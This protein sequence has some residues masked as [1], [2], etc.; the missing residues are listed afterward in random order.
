MRILEN[1][2]RKNLK[3]KLIW[4]CCKM[5]VYKDK[6]CICKYMA[7]LKNFV[8]SCISTYGNLPTVQYDKTSITYRDINSFVLSKKANNDT[9][10]KMRENIIGA[11]INKN[12]P[13][14]F[15]KY[16]PRW[17]L[18]KKNIDEYLMKVIKERSSDVNEIKSAKCIHRGG[19]LY[20][21]DFT[22]IINDS[23]DF[24]IELKFNASNI[25]E[26]PQYV[27]P[28]KPSQYLSSSFEE[29]YYENFLPKL[30]S[31]SNTHLP[32][33][34][35]DEYMK[36]IH[37]PSPSCVEEF[38]AKYYRGCK[39][40]SKYSGLE[41]DI[42]FYNTAI[43]LSKESISQFIEKTEL[44]CEKLSDYL[45]ETQKDKIYMLFKDNKF[46]MDKPNI[47]DYT[48]VGYTKMP[49]KAMYLANSQTGNKIKIL[50]RWKNGNGIAYP[51]FQIS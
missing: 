1:I 22:V 34:N 5:L 30:A 10:N 25:K 46:Y 13:E 2:K 41:E 19:R 11:I 12:I 43:K 32:I 3:R 44:D 31:S 21:Y 29:Y 35:K 26:T 8:K 6:S 14:S 4:N 23:M 40:S 27:S 17:S 20:H 18:M 45:I 47:G 38:Q 9:N 36:T 37:G 28:M 49:T 50:L 33:P 51:A 42:N 16:S 39:N 7:P 15:Y 48:I 24:N